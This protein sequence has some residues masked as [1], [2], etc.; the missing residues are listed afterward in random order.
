MDK[1]PETPYYAAI[2]TSVRTE[3]DRG[4]SEMSA[5]M[6]ELAREQEGFLGMESARNETGITVSYWRDLDCIRKW[7]NHSEHLLAQAKGKGKWYQSFKVRIA[8]VEKE[9][10]FEKE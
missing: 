1:T 8:K 5:R 2:F 6:V 3:G 9:Y 10:G 7:K 4:Y